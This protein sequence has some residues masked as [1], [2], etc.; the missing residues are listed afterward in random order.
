MMPGT[1][2][3]YIGLRFLSA[4]F[5][6]FVGLIAVVAMVDFIEMLRRLSDVP[7]AS[8]LDIA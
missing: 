6:V 8:T 3:R 1:L 7:D 5:V 4:F 2:A